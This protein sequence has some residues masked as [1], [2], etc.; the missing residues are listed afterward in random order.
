[1]VAVIDI[2]ASV[3]TFVVISQAMVVYSLEQPFGGK[4]LTEDIQRHYNLSWAEAGKAKR[5]GG[6]GSDYVETMLDPFKD[7]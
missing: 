2:G 6:L 5:K 3:F 1:M 7:C 4:Q